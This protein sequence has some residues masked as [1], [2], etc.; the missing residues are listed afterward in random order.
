MLSVNSVSTKNYCK[1]HQLNI[2]E[3]FSEI[4]IY[5]DI[6]DGFTRCSEKMKECQKI[7]ATVDADL[8]NNATLLRMEIEAM[9]ECGLFENALDEWEELISSNQNWDAFQFQFEDAEEKFNLKKKIH[10]KKG[11]SVKLTWS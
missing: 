7:A 1:L 5:F 11:A 8:I 2:S 10:D 4:S 9:Y 3:L 6:N